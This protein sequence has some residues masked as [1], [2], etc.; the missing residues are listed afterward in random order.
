MRDP[1]LTALS[2]SHRSLEHQLAAVD[3]AVKERES[4]RVVVQTTDAFMIHACR[5][6]SAM[7]AVVLPILR[8]ELPD[9]RRRVRLYIRQAKRLERSMAQ[10]KRRLYG[11][12]HHG[13]LLVEHAVRG[14]NGREQ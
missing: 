8:R 1:L 9:G 12:T 10:A 4:T 5:H 11:A 7:C 3:R 6:V 13:E 14:L 2:G